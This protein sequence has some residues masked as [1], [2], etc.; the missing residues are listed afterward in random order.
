MTDQ[1]GTHETREQ[2]REKELAKA[3]DCLNIIQFKPDNHPYHSP[4]EARAKPNHRL[5]EVFGIKNIFTDAGCTGF[6]VNTIRKM[7]AACKMTSRLD[8]G[9]WTDLR[10]R[11]ID[12][13]AD[14]IQRKGQLE[15]I[16]LAGL[17]QFVTL[18]L[19]LSYLFDDAEAAFK[20]HDTFDDITYIGQQINE[21][22]MK[23]K[24]TNNTR[25]QWNDQIKLHQALRNVTTRSMPG[26][27]P[28]DENSG[29]EPTIPL[30]NPMN[31]LL[32]AYETMWRVVMRCFIEVQLRGAKN[33]PEWIAILAE[34]LEE[35]N[36]PQC[37]SRKVFQKASPSGLRPIDIAKETLRLHPPSRRVH[38]DFDG[39]LVRAD[40][41]ACHRSKL[42][43]GEDPLVFRPERWLDI[44][45][46][47]RGKR[48]E[49]DFSTATKPKN[50]TLKQDETTLG[51]MPF[52]TYCTADKS[53]TKAFA[54]KMIVLLVAV[55]CRG[56][57]DEWML[58]DANSLPD[59]HVPLESDREAY[60]DLCLKKV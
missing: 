37:M 30:E 58:A 27:F 35:L 31:L 17:V 33:G 29:V 32:P 3:R 8:A 55:L 57:G 10:T 48:Y 38:R 43:G 54:M 56:L 36:D 18:K 44:C 50:D 40:I 23:S 15:S 7:K 13:F 5:V 25:P 45:P 39:K 51:F 21:L 59:P 49:A 34:Y 41:E 53:E 2:E 28:G 12:Y 19:S 42:L 26:S 4:R 1:I 46:E 14:Y 16:N 60:G 6:S 22:W 24:N 9:D 20:T 52:A 47:Q 11:A